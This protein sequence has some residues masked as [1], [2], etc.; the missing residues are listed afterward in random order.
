[1]YSSSY[2]FDLFLK[3][4]K[5]PM[6]IHV[7]RSIRLSA[8]RGIIVVVVVVVVVKRFIVIMVTSNHNQA[9]YSKKCSLVIVK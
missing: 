8:E 1:M 6:L 3:Y 7:K 9:E 2:Y 4:L 5:T